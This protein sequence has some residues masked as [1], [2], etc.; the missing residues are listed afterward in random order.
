MLRAQERAAA[1][2][3]AGATPARPALVAF[4]LLLITLLRVLRSW[5]S[6]SCSSEEAAL[7]IHA[8]A[9]FGLRHQSRLKPLFSLIARAATQGELQ[10]A[11]EI[12]P[13]FRTA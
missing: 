11:P 4:E 2:A 6:S 8:T 13:S 5:H 9:A 3:D 7:C 12:T 10:A 1:P